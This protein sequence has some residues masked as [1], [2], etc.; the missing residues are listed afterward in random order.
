MM[1]CYVGTKV[2]NAQP[3]T[4]G[5]YNIFR[6]WELPEGEQ[7]T[8]QDPGY[9]VE[10]VDNGVGTE[11]NTPHFSGYV[12]WS[13]KATFEASY[14]HVKSLPFGIA[15]EML[16][17][18]YRVTRE[19]W[20]GKGMFLQYV[21]PYAVHIDDVPRFDDEPGIYPPHLMKRPGMV[22]S[23]FRPV[24]NN[25]MAPGTML[26]WIGMKTAD[27]KF[28]PWLASQTDLLAHDWEVL[29]VESSF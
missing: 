29:N 5:D 22:N 11:P 14:V 4:R 13:P 28:V 9:L 15:L 24:D 2:V 23:L 10:Y 21:N 18:G 8:E 7:G 27:N 25:G 20:N 19:G 16:K 1:K 6:G 12:S 3:M 17:Q 26:P